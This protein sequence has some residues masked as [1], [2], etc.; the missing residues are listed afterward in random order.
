MAESEKKLDHRSD[1]QM[2]DSVDVVTVVLIY[3]TKY[4]SDFGWGSL[5]SLLGTLCP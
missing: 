2:S 3:A 1:F 4:G 5:T